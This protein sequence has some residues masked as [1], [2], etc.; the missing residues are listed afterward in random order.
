ML[1]TAMIKVLAC[2]VRAW[3]LLFL[4]ASL[5]VGAQAD[6]AYRA[7]RD[8]KSD[9]K[10]IVVKDLTL[11]RDVFRFHFAAGTFQFLTSVEGRPYE[12]LFTG[13]GTL[14]LQPATEGERRYLGFV[15]EDEFDRVVDPTKMVKPYVATA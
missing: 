12:A 7:L 15:T 11:E 3:W 13:E 5:A 4:T 10:A 2:G 1:K 14:E 9:G 6:P 8:A